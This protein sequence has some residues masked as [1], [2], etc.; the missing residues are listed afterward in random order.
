Q[1]SSPT[2]VHLHGTVPRRA[3]D[4]GRVATV[5]RLRARGADGLAGDLT[6]VDALALIAEPRAALED[7]PASPTALGGRARRERPESAHVRGVLLL[8]FEEKR[9][10]AGVD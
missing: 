4:V 7:R 2:S 8:S 10:V 9:R 3:D 6:H 5:A 1:H